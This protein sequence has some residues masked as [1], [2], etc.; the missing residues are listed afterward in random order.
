MPITSPASSTITNP[1]PYCLFPFSSEKGSPFLR[2]NPTLG[3]LIPAGLDISS[4]AEAQLFSPGGGRRSSGREQ[5]L[6][7]NLLHLL[8]DPHEDQGTHLQV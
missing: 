7:Q 6:R 4:L 3:H 8:K 1:F 2:Y 5:R